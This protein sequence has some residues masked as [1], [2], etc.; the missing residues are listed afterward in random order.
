MSYLLGIDIGTTN[1]KAVLF[2]K[3]GG[4]NWGRRSGLPHFPSPS[5]MGASAAGR[6]VSGSRWRSKTSFRTNG[7]IAGRNYVR[8]FFRAYTHNFLFGRKI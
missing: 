5:G 6:L 2:D 4:G 1:V 3:K 7:D 8:R